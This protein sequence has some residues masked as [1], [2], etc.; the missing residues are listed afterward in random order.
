MPARPPAVP[1]HLLLGALHVVTLH[2]RGGGVLGGK[3][4]G[5]GGAGGAQAQHCRQAERREGGSGGGRRRV[6]MECGM[7]HMW[8]TI[9]TAL[10]ANPSRHVGWK[11]PL[12][13]RPPDPAAPPAECS[14]RRRSPAAAI[15]PSTARRFCTSCCCCGCTAE[16][17]TVCRRAVCTRVGACTQD[18]R[19]AWLD[20]GT[21]Y[22]RKAASCG[23]PGARTTAILE[24]VAIMVR[25][26]WCG[27][28][29]GRL[30]TVCGCAI[31][32]AM[33]DGRPASR[34]HEMGWG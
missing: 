16:H 29:L 32:S 2:G 17:T 31:D 10:H 7:Q 34:V 15:R 4:G 26:V 14:P 11:R 8:H 6:S 27:G 9:P 33:C 20:A 24:A 5:L 1:I 21:C 19:G 25:V 22:N 13:L 30:E 23:Q 12:S 3:V 28:A 18:R